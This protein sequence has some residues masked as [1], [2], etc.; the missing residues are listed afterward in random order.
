MNFS[1]KNKTQRLSV[2][3]RR[4]RV[5]C[6]SGRPA[7]RVGSGWV[8][9]AFF[10]NFAGRFG[11]GPEFSGSGRVRESVGRVGLQNPDPS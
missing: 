8:G 6:G 10:G 3:L 1:T 4:L 7:G 5:G 9:S 11:L 2:T